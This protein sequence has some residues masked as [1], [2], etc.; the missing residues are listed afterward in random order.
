LTAVSA[1]RVGVLSLVALLLA[2]EFADELVFGVR[3]AAWPLIRDDAGLDYAQVGLLIGLPN[4]ASAVT[5]PLIGILGDTR[6]R[7]ALIAGGG[8]VYAIAL[9]VFA[10][11]DTFAVL[12]AASFFIYPASGAFVSLSQV[13]LIAAAPSRA[14]HLMARWAL[15]GSVGVV[16]GPAFLAACVY[17]G[18]GWRGAVATTAAILALLAVATLSRRPAQDAGVEHLALRDAV[19]GTLD[20]TR[21]RAVWKWLALLGCSDLMLDVLLGFLALYV[22]DVAGGSQDAASLAVAIWAIAGLAGDALLLPLLVRMPGLRY[23]RWSARF[24]LLVFPLFLLTPWLP[25]KLALLALLGILNAGWY[26][27]LKAQLYDALPGRPGATMA[28]YAGF[29]SLTGLAPVAL[30]MVADRWGLETAMWILL[31]GPVALIIGLWKARPGA[32]AVEAT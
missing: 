25:G 16:A 14:E 28:I 20:A 23:L 30:G 26:A 7:R 19:R 3:E 8:F 6:W 5:E 10:V 31:A 9:A 21:S 4:L 22:V 29:S 13:S 17:L 32:P 24:T 11:G 1:W 18:V 2:I 15:A 12:L 27:I